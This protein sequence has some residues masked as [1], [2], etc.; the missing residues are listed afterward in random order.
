MVKFVTVLCV[1][2][3][4]APA[5]EVRATLGGRVT[6]PTGAM[7]AGAAVS[8]VSDETAVQRQTT[9]NEQGNWLVQFLIPGHYH[10]SVSAPGFK[11][12]ERS[13][14]ELQAA[15]N[16][17]IDTRLEVGQASQ[18]LEVTAET[19]LIDT[20][21]ATSGT[22]ITTQE[23][24]EMPL[25][26]HVVTLL[27]TLSPGVV[28]QDQNGNVAHMWSYLAASEFEADGGRNNKY[29]NNFQLDGMPDTQHNG[30]VAFIPPM[31]SVQE[32]RVATNAYD[33]SI[34]R[35]AGSTVQLQT[36]SGGEHYHGSMYEFDQNNI[37]NANLFQ[38]N[39]VGGTVPPVHFNEWG[40]TFGGP[41]YI[42]KLYHGQQKTFFFFSYDDTWNEDP[43]PGSTRSVPTAL[44]RQGNFSESFTTQAGQRFPIQIYDPMSVDA[45]GNRTIFPGMAI[46]A[47]RLN[48]ISTSILKYVPLPNTAS[49]PT[50]NASNNF[51]S[52]ATRADKFPVISVRGD[53]NWNNSQRSF[54][55]V[56]WSHLHEFLDDYFHDAATGNFQ[57]RVPKAISVDHV[58]TMSPTRIL[59]LRFNLSR[60]EDPNY[61]KGAGFNPTQLGFASNFAAEMVKP[62][63]PYIKGFAG[64]FGTNQAGKYYDNNYYTLAAHLTQVHHNHTLKF[65]ADY[66][67]LQ[68][69]DGSLGVQPEFDFGGEWTRQNALYSGGTGV[70]STFASYLLGLPTG[71]NEPVNATGY[72]TQHYTAL[73]FQDD[74][75]VTSRLT[76]NVGMRWDFETPVTERYNRLTSEFDLSATNPISPTAQAA[77]ASI[78]ADPKNANNAG[79]QQLKQLLPASAFRV[80]GVVLFAGVNGQ[81][82]G[83]SN[84]DY[85]EWQPRAGFAYRLGSNTVIRGGFGRFTQADYNYGGQNG[86]S[87]TTSFVATQDNWMTPYDTLS[88]PFRGGIYAP[89]GSSLGA[90]TNLGAGVDFNDPNPDRFYSWEY[91]LHLQHQFKNWLFEAGYS[92]NKT[93]DIAWTRQQDNPSAALWRQLDGPQFDGSGRPLD[94]LAW[95][96]VVPNP[97]YHLSGISPSASIYSSK[98]TTVNHL[99]YS[100]PLLGTLTEKTMP[101][102]KNQYDAML[103]K[104]ERRFSKGFSVLNSFTWSK[105]FEDTSLLGPEIAG[106]DV[107][108]KL[109]GEDRPFHFTTSP[110]WELPIGRGKKLGYNMSH[111]LDMIVGGWELAGTYDI[112]SGVP[113]AFGTAS[114]FCGHDFSL[115]SAASTSQWFDTSCFYPFPN[116]LTD[117][118]TY[119][120]WT[121]V[122]SLPGASYVPKAGDTIRNGVYQDFATYVRNYPTRWGNVRASRVNNLDIG[123]YKNLNFTERFR[124]QLRFDAFNALN[125]VRFPAPDTNPASDT[126]GRVKLQEENQAR[127]VELGARLSF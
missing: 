37:L 127:A 17:Q 123:L 23:I 25:A 1:L 24:T 10:F 101:L 111:P 102:G 99:L 62:S 76:V 31:D 40:A 38:T 50:S 77:Y 95:N 55:A 81:T 49:D 82:R 7:I 84:P 74:W 45:N 114:F 72:Y 33:A 8:V 29:S 64:N 120:A 71:G 109:G 54:I 115:G 106:I 53:Q 105:L 58:W 20:T 21:A 108:H 11:T 39:L 113:V 103:V 92:H 52:S 63:F 79:V 22:V 18:T 41:V 104:V 110:I 9:T 44:E 126:F 119:P 4:Q 60:Y 5:Q 19:P 122:M 56:R 100:D 88:N 83:F 70:G 96:D 42:P 116:K 32:F 46:P 2:A 6:D 112:Q 12:T 85:H 36:R 89:T 121:G 28:A 14:I 34:G 35:Q 97:F 94:I 26:S 118:S 61:N 91:S 48:P 51:V 65:G 3:N 66:W 59:D 16:K 80:P 75:R 73:Y 93:Y 90:L 30:N 87:R 98:T 67:V 125:H 27:A 124:L 47:S 107:E 57:E 13:G 78:L 68:D 86:F 117:I 15:D 69:A 43:R